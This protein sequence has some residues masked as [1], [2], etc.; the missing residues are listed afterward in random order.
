MPSKSPKK[1]KNP[2]A[3]LYPALLVIGMGIA[4]GSLLIN[5]QFPI[6]L[7]LASML[8]PTGAKVLVGGFRIKHWL[9]G[10]IVLVGGILAYFT[11][12]KHSLTKQIGT[13]LIGIGTLLIIDE[14]ESIIRTITTGQ[15]P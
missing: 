13:V 11:E 15:Y 2:P 5:Q 10:V 14:P 4:Y 6:T 3:F 12:D 8:S 7:S 1:P 9:V